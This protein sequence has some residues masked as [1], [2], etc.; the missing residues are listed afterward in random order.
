MR[1]V[2]RTPAHQGDRLA[3]LVCSNSMGSLLQDRALGILK[4]EL[5]LLGSLLVRTACA[6][7]LPGGAALTI[8][9]E[10]FAAEITSRIGRHPLIDLRRDES[11]RFPTGRPSSPRDR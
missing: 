5:L 10:A 8:D 9:R 1:P 3:E 2:R 6:H 7:S 4:R 11:A